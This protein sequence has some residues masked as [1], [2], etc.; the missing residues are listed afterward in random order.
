MEVTK[1]QITSTKY[2]INLNA[3]FAPSPFPSPQR[4]EGGGERKFQISLA[5]ILELFGICDLGFGIFVVPK[6]VNFP[7]DTGV[8][9]ELRCYRRRQ[10][11]GCKNPFSF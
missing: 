2:Q 6:D 5:G 11:C 4:G 7:G 1:H 9:K 10:I 3:N 8:P